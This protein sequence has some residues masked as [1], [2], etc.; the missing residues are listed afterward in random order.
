MKHTIDKI[1]WGHRW[2]HG[3]FWDDLFRLEARIKTASTALMGLEVHDS[4]GMTLDDIAS[5]LH[6]LSQKAQKGLET[7]KKRAKSRRV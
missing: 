6:E 7:Y 5:E 3:S 4:I 1:L 2:R